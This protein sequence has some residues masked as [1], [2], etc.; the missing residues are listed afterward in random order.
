M[1]A[2][3]VTTVKLPVTLVGTPNPAGIG[4]SNKSWLDLLSRSVP[5]LDR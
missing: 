2:M 1:V 3:N 5:P 4:T